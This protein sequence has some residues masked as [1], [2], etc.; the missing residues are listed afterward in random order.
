ME[1]KV[2]VSNEKIAGKFLNVWE[3]NG[4]LLFKKI[5]LFIYLFLVVMGL[6]CRVSFPL[7]AAKGSCS[8][9]SARDS[10][11]SG[12]AYC[13]P[14]A[15]RC[16]GFSSCSSWTLE[17]RLHCST[18]CGILQD[19][20]SNPCLLHWQQVDSLPLSYQGGLKQYTSKRLRFK[21]KLVMEMF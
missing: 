10:H 5:I 4:T 14:Q 15:L 7:V 6:F 19:Q 3:L 12:F 1:L 8:N 9:C 11:C 13:R 20:G 21:E 17:H 16:L 2:A 18:A